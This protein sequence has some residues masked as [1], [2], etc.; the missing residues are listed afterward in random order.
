MAT[1]AWPYAVSRDERSGY[2][3]VV[4]PEFLADARQAYVLEFA[5]KG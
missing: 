1:H 3:A 2:H 4:V 5:S